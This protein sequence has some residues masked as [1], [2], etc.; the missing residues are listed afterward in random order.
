MKLFFCNYTCFFFILPGPC[1]YKFLKGI[2][3]REEK[4]RFLIK[5]SGTA[6]IHI[7]SCGSEWPLLIR[8]RIR[9]TERLFI[10]FIFMNVIPVCAGGMRTGTTRWS[11]RRSGCA[12]PQ[13][14]RRRRLRDPVTPQTEPRP[15][16]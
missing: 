2:K 13:T 6:R 16:W 11:R 8:I 12:S 15:L 5:P 14:K 10:I 3:N 7:F 4:L 9:N 1:F